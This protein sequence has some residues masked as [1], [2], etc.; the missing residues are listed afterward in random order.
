MDL[1]LYTTVSRVELSDQGSVCYHM[2][3]RA[4]VLDQVM[5]QAGQDADQEIFRN[6][7]RNAES[8][9]EA[10]DAKDTS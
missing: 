6:I 4:V 8:T 1:P 3:D 5:R 10:S 7:L 2:F 9:V